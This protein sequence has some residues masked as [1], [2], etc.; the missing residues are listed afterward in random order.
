MG[1]KVDDEVKEDTVDKKK[2][3]NMQGEEGVERQSVI[4]VLLKRS[5]RRGGGGGV[6]VQRDEG[7][8]RARGGCG[9]RESGKETRA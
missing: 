6:C 8:N 9:G 4:T 1:A 7:D 2:I 3:L 5:G